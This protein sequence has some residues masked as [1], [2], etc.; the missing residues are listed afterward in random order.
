MQT[1]AKVF[2]FERN[3]L[4][5]DRYELRRMGKRVRLSRSLT[6]L[7]RLLVE[8]R[9][10]LVTRDEIAAHL[11]TNPEMVD[12]MQGINTAVNRLRG[13]LNDDPS[14]PRFIETVVGKGYRFIAE[15]EEI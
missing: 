14:K 4:D 3:E 8:R 1:S 15:V 7:L 12:V 6:E 2:R 5:I 9:G 11:W 10:K 13:A